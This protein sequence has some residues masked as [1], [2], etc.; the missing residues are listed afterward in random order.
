MGGGEQH[1]PGTAPAALLGNANGLGLLFMVLARSL[2]HSRGEL[3]EVFTMREAVRLWLGLMAALALAFAPAAAAQ[4][5]YEGDY[6]YY[7][8][9]DGGW[10]DD[11]ESDDDWFFDTYEYDEECD[12]DDYDY[13]GDNYYD[14][15]FGYDYDNDVFDWEEDG[16]F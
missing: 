4:D 15:D 2:E 8:C 5:Y 11:G 16:L 13:D 7:E 14:N 9:Y 10:L 6:D 1:T 3:L 12:Y